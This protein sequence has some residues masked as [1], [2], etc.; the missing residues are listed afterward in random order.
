MPLAVCFLP[1]NAG[2]PFAFAWPYKGR[3]NAYGARR[4]NYSN[5]H[6]TYIL[7]FILREA[8]ALMASAAVANLARR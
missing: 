2:V 8:T 7:A 6:S 4:Q 3:A 5:C 1:A